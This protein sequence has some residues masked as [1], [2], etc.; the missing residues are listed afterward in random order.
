MTGFGRATFSLDDTHASV[1]ISSVNR[2]Q[3]EMALSCA[4]DLN[5]L[6]SAIRPIVFQHVSRGRIQVNLTVTRAAQ[7]ATLLDVDIAMAQALD[8]AFARL[9]ATLQRDLTPNASDFLR[10]PGI[11]R[12]QEQTMDAEQVWPAI[13]PALHEALR[14][15]QESRASEGAALE[16]DLRSRLDAIANIVAQ[17]REIAPTRA[18]R[19]AELLGKRL[20]EL[21]CPIDPSDERLLKEI[22]LFA[23]RCDISEE[24]T[25]LDAHLEKFQS[26]LMGAEPPGRALD[27][28]CQE[29]HRELNT[30]GSKASDATIAQS[31]VSGKTELEKIRE[32]VQ[33]IE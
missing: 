5:S 30:I 23:D 12:A 15:F 20:T 14:I 26:Y 25:R 31:V 28:L 19:Q 11:I 24:I 18:A 13:E 27:F 21:N 10:V 8:S 2:K 7:E 22:A 16:K 4:R 9:S 6:E 3:A 33:N 1:E 29:I 32:Q 17:I